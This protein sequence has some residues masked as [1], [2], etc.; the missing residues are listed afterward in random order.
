M[1]SLEY[2]LLESDRLW[3]RPIEMKDADNIYQH[4]LKK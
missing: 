4:L 2:L 3:L 1:L